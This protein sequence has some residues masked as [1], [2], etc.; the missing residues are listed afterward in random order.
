MSIVIPSRVFI[1][2]GDTRH[3]GGPVLHCHFVSIKKRLPRLLL[4]R[5]C[6]AIPK[7][8]LVRSQFSSVGARVPLSSRTPIATDLHS[9]LT[10]SIIS[11]DRLTE[12]AVVVSKH[13]RQ[14]VV[15]SQSGLPSR[16][17]S[18]TT[19]TEQGAPFNRVAET[20]PGW[21]VS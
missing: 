9:K 15:N 2:S 16:L 3:A 13:L 12:R 11:Y 1:D 21:P 14:L 6:V 19:S 10:Y 4:E 8:R 20:I 18:R 7:I 17:P 5:L